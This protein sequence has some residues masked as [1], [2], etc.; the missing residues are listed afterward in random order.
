VLARTQAPKLFA[1]PAL[2]Q[3]AP[4]RSFTTYAAVANFPKEEVS[5]RLDRLYAE[6]AGSNWG[7]Y[8]NIVMDGPFWQAELEQLDHYCQPYLA[9]PEIGAKMKK[10]HEMFDCME[11][12]TDARDFMNEMGELCTRASGFM[13][14]GLNP[15]PKVENLEEIQIHCAQ[16]YEEMLVKYPDFK[17]KTEQVLGHGLAVLRQKGKFRFDQMH[18]YMF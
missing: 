9:D 2:L 10:L 4:P 11:Q 6:V 15:A 18:R 14:T 13:G 5:D 3:A 7:D 16:F 1:A 17:P 12:L 8:F